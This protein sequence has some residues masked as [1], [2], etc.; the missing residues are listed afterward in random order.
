M[1]VEI[2]TT[3]TEILLGE[4]AN[5][6]SRYL[7]RELNKMGY[8]VVYHTTV[9]D[10]PD[11]M[12]TALETALKRA[13]LVITTGGLGPTQGD[14]TKIIGAQLME[15]PLVYDKYV[16]VKIAKWVQLHHPGQE[17]TEN[18]KR[19]AM[20]PQGDGAF[21]FNNEVGTAPGVAMQRGTKTLVHLPGPPEEM[22]WMFEN[23]L[24][25]WLLH[26]FGVQGYIQSEYLKVYDVGEAVLEEA[27]MDLI[28]EQSNPTLAM[29]ARPG[30]VEVRL[31]AKAGSM[32]E[33]EKLI[34]PLE[35]EVRRRLAG[36][37]IAYDD[38]TIAAV[39]GRILRRQSLTVSAA[40]SCTGGL[41]GS[42]LTDVPGASEY[43]RGSAGTYCDEMKEKILGVPPQ[44]LQ[45]Y[46]AVSSQTAAAM[47]YGSRR[48]YDADLA[49]STTGIAG[50]GGGTKTQPV[51]LVYTGIS[52]PWGTKTYKNIYH[53]GR[54]EVKR[55]AAIGAIYYLVQY[56]AD[57]LK[58]N[59]KQ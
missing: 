15:Y 5:F 52:G 40:E 51:G 17:I 46:T 41:V 18:Q 55:R 8:S 32:T 6:N 35:T 56:L 54:E 7:S 37:I 13:D 44:V 38:E 48:L 47:S 31:T 2:V 24:K 45:E 11:R 39:L 49:V 20:I 19:Q 53:G 25:P 1:L 27:L 23:R 59:L 12:R 34:H 58:E 26:T 57:H 10:N 28:K 33:A 3:G 16:A 21:I 42:L 4:I 9:G 22:K 36:H 30:F 14:M 43:F 29:Y 50:P